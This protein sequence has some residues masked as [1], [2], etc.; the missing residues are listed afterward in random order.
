MMDTPSQRGL[1]E[2]LDTKDN[3][4]MRVFFALALVSLVA[5]LLI[6][7]LGN[8]FDMESFQLV[9]RLVN[10]GKTA[11]AETPRYNYGPVW[12]GMLGAARW[13]QMWLLDS[14]ALGI[15]HIKIAGLLAY[16]DVVLAFALA[17]RF[18]YVAGLL[19]LLNPV[20]LLL[21]GY[22]SQFDNLAVMMGLL[23]W[24]LVCGKPGEHGGGTEKRA[25]RELWWGAGLLGLSLMT[26]HILIFFPLW[27][28][29]R[30]DV[31]WRW[32][33]ALTA[34]PYGL[35][36]LGFVPFLFDP[37]S[38]EGVVENVFKYRVSYMTG[39]Y[40][41]LVNL[42][43]PQNVIDRA[44]GWIPVFGGFKAVWFVSMMA[45]GWLLRRVPLKEY[46][47]FYLVAMVVF[48]VQLADQYLAIPLIACAVFWRSPWTWAYGILT[49][50]YLLCSPDNIGCQP[51][52]EQQ[53]ARISQLGITY[54]RPVSM[55]F[56]FLVLRMYAE[57]RALR[58][59]RTGG[60]DN[61]ANQP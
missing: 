11:Y 50:I 16:A 19:F 14:D 29:F 32:K 34:I 43:V 10:D 35:F 51:F 23:G 54:W 9:A 18:S 7:C 48:S 20:S 28:W 17:V 2:P 12:M 38:R 47:L 55:L 60:E 49:I 52:L 25:T 42:V 44:L 1:D 45:A 39:F 56:I 21:T 46:L 37:A 58:R 6:A 24:L 33:L 27:I 31:T 30:R 57:G 61:R 5:K 3:R 13:L 53:A 22:H 40:P 26:K 15:L 41:R 36:L 59:P 8:T 4:R